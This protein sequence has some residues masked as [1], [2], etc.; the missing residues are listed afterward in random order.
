MKF[1]NKILYLSL[2]NSLKKKYGVNR[3]VKKED[4]KI[5]L[6]RQYL[7]PKNLRNIAIEELI[8]M[9]LITVEDTSYVKILE[10]EF[11]LENSPNKFFMAIGRLCV[12][13]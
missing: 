7:V 3:L 2:H 8:E 10:G 11:D 13:L 5:K 1:N 6:G 4:V 12:I 9:K